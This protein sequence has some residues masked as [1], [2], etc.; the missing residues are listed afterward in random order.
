MIVTPAAALLLTLIALLAEAAFGYPPSI[1]RAIS[2]PVVWI[3]GLIG[4]LDRRLNKPEL[5]DF[6]RRLRGTLALLFLLGVVFLAALCA[7]FI[8]LVACGR[9]VG[10]V[11]LAIAASSL[12]AQ[13]SLHAHVMA[14]A[15][16]LDRDGLKGG[17]EAVSQ[18]VGR[19]PAHLDEAGVC[20]AAIESLAENFSDGVVAP[21]FWGCLLGLA[22]I[23][24]YKAVNTADSMI[25]H[26]TPKHAAFGWAAARFDDVIN[27]PASRLAAFFVLVAAA[28]TGGDWRAGRRAVWR[29]A[30]HHRSPNAGWPE[31]AMAGA[32]GLRL[33]GP[34]VYG[35]TLVADGWMGDGR[36]AVTAGDLR[37]ALRLYRAACA[38]QIGVVAILAAIGIS[39][40]R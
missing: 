30:G 14:V 19:N 11:V 29:D 12:F 1:Y 35:E 26:R 4:W 32:L 20:R 23:A 24:G 8:L 5:S 28:L 18:I 39:C 22:G 36:A 34:R 16:G 31:A 15:D 21:A 2:H 9:W 40:F 10:L 13:R 25:G 38:V 37:R 33:A 17:R 7:D 6:H 3:G 27:L